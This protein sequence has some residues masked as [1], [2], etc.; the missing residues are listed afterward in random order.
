MIEIEQSEKTT[1]NKTKRNK[2]ARISDDYKHIIDSDD[3][4]V[5]F[6]DPR[7][8]YVNPEPRNPY[9]RRLVIN[10]FEKYGR[11]IRICG[12]TDTSILQYAKKIC[13]GRECLASVAIAGA[14][15]KDISEYRKE[16][17]IT[18][19]R[20]P[21]D[22]HGPC[23]N[24][25]WPVLWDTFSKRLNLKN[26]IFCAFPK[27]TNGYLG[28]N[29]DLLAWENLYFILGQYFIEARNALQCVAENKD[30]ALEKFEQITDEFITNIKEEKK[31]LNTGLIKWARDISKIPLKAT[32]EETPKVLI[33]GGLNLM[34]DHY[35]VE[36]F[37]LEKGIIPKVVDI[38]ETMSLILAESSIRYGFKKGY[39]KPK[40]QY[41]SKLYTAEN[42]NDI[43]QKEVTRANRN[44]S[45]LNFLNS[46]CKT[47][48]KQMTKS[49]LLFDS[50]IEFIDLFE[51]GSQYVSAN[52]LS[53]TPIITGR[54]LHSIE[55]N[56]YDGL[57][58]MG[59]FNCQPAMNSQAIIRPLANKSDISYAAIDCEGPWISTNQQRLLETI[60]I[61]AKRI[62]KKKNQLLR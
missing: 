26:V 7:I 11:K 3:Q 40:E 42:L 50:Y 23:Q 34:F 60:A 10:L 35:P 39:I 1:I 16:N 55:E 8:V 56:V 6:D 14:V 46:Q 45:A 36:E 22:N 24:G 30:T 61:Q 32:V 18:I 13:S 21:I 20:T 58:N 52:S 48:R 38:V 2:Q 28:L 44:R 12:D 57:V 31:T 5:E 4:K 25:A 62:R 33:F 53:E 51:K 27:F 37:F 29:R 19:Y 47:F 15:L 54:F 17:E 9:G 43:D 49:G 41:N 59:T